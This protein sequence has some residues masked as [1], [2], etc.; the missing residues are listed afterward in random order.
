MGA[1]GAGNFQNDAAAEQLTAV[2]GALTDETASL[3]RDDEAVDPNAWGSDII[4]AN[5]EMLMALA[6]L[7]RAGSGGFMDE[8]LRPRAL[9]SAETLE[10]WKARYLAVWDANIDSAATEGF[11]D[12]RRRVAVATFDKIIAMA[13]ADGS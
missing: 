9:P 6:Q 13:G 7:G 12:E 11:A 3:I 8:A 1:W 2:C 4:L 10:A 5:L